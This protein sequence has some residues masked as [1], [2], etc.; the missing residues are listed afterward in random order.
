MKTKT[1]LVPMTP[2]QVFKMQVQGVYNGLRTE[3]S[4]KEYIPP[5]FGGPHGQRETIDS[6]TV[7]SVIDFEG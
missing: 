6:N 7:M 3:K 2:H 4:E 1:K 5:Q